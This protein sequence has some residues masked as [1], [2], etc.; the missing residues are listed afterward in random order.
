MKRFATGFVIDLLAFGLLN[1]MAHFVLPSAIGRTD[2]VIY[3]GY[4]FLVWL[5]GGETQL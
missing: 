3:W 5:E 1:V 4:P 2:R